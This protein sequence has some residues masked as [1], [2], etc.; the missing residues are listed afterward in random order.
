MVESRVRFEEAGARLGVDLA[1][2]VEYVGRGSRHFGGWRDSG[3]RFTEASCVVYNAC[4]VGLCV[5]I[6][7]VE[8]LEDGVRN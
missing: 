8:V 5:T 1:C 4:N 7:C 3:I 2:T 6:G